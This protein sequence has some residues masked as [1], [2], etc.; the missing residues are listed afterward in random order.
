[1][2]A[3][4]FGHQL[5]DECKTNYWCGI[6]DITK[7]NLQYSHLYKCRQI[8]KLFIVIEV[9]WL[10]EHTHELFKLEEKYKIFPLSYFEKKY[11]MVTTIIG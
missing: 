11:K 7:G 6:Q 5:R 2:N 10:M 1:M 4:L 3:V 8:L 9:A